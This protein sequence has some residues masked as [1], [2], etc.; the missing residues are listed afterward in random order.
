MR[1]QN[2]EARRAPP[3]RTSRKMEPAAP[4][5]SELVSGRVDLLSLPE[6]V[7][8][9]MLDDSHPHIRDRYG[10]CEHYYISSAYHPGELY[11]TV[12]TDICCR[13]GSLVVG[14]WPSSLSTPSLY[15]SLSEV[16]RQP[17]GLRSVLRS[18]PYAKAQPGVSTQALDGQ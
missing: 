15:S 5:F 11:K 3:D 7:F 10:P 16:N 2:S 18:E 4:T 8:C 1:A 14:L 6:E 12:K 13:V 9:Y 17:T